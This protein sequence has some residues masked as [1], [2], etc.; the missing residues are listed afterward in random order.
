M[1]KLLEKIWDFVAKDRSLTLQSRMFRLLCL[2]A[3]VICL[4]LCLPSNLLEPELPLSVDVCTFLAGILGLFCYIKALRGREYTLFFL[5]VLILLI[6][7]IW[8]RNGGSQ[9]SNTYYF[10]AIIVYPMSIWRGRKR[11]CFAG[12]IALNICGL[13][14]LEFYFP[15]LVFRFSNRAEIFLDILTGVLSA[16]A[17]V[18][19]VTWA[20]VTN[21]DWEQSR[22]SLVARELGASEENYRSLVET[23]TCLI[24][25]LDADG[26]IIFINRFAEN[27]LGFGRGELTG[28]PALGTIVP[29]TSSAGE[30]LSAR[31]TDL[32]REP[33]R[34]AV[35]ENEVHSRD[36]R[37]VWVRWGNV[38]IRDEAGRLREIL[39]VGIDLTE[40]KRAED[41]LRETNRNLE[42]ATARA[43]LANAAKSDFLANMSHEI[44][45]PMNGI[46]GMANLLLDSRLDVHQQEFTQYII[47]SSENLLNIIND[48]LDLSKIEYNQMALEM[49]PFNLRDLV[50]DILGLLAPRAQAKGVELNAILP[51]GLP[52][53]LTGDP[54]RVRQILMNLLGNSI[55]FTEAGEVTL[56]VECLTAGAELARL[57]FHVS[58]TG[59]GIA[60]EMRERLF[61][62]FSQGDASTTRRYG[63]TGLGLAICKRLVSLMNG[64]IGVDSQPGKG[65][66]FWFEIELSRRHQPNLL[67]T[68]GGRELAKVRVLVADQ[69]AATRESILAMVQN[70]TT[71]HYEA[72]R[73]ASALEMLSRLPADGVPVVLIAGQLPDMSGEEL[74]NRAAV[75]RRQLHTLLI[76]A[77]EDRTGTLP[78]N[79]NG[80][81]YKP[82]RQSSLFNT[83]QTALTASRPPANSPVPAE[84]P[85]QPALAL[86]P[87]NRLG[88]LKLLVV[89]DN[90]INRRLIE[91]MLTKLGCRPDMVV[92]GREAVD[93]WRARRPDVILMDCQLPV[94]DGY[95]ATREIRLLEAAEPAGTRPVYIIA[96][97]ANA[98]KGD[99]EKCL[100]VGMDECLSKPVRPGEL[101]AFLTA[102]A[103]QIHPPTSRAQL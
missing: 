43:E 49:A 51:A 61:L 62:P 103:D 25:R 7:I 45:T 32:L 86:P 68:V 47:Q 56:R 20:V 84:V 52:V 4:G 6:D 87:D 33:E 73:G 36:G 58:D 15:G 81:I 70:W 96:V 14:A 21:Y 35:N 94:L 5:V 29:K 27:L 8:V 30:N 74:C 26:R 60:D 63:G 40:Q 44:R 77:M 64:D 66:H 31:F 11:W 1:D 98:M 95:E 42:Q 57:R 19:L 12:L 17:G 3:A 46:L 59:I 97:T 88:R 91:L 83:L 102:A 55:K 78:A 101:T 41:T 80:L 2:S 89:E 85:V 28:R 50:D 10:L 38:P 24:L 100:A 65:S 54:V 39:C 92:N 93:Y 82:V 13:F 99:R 34:F 18:A 22:L 9:G 37:L 69:H 53:E 67:E 16:L 23:A 72:A 76:R 75:R 48:L 90:A 79:V 71:H